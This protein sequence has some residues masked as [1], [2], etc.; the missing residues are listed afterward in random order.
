MP[1]RFLLVR[2]QPYQAN[3][4]R[5]RTALHKAVDGPGVEEIIETQDDKLQEIKQSVFSDVGGPVKLNA[6]PPVLVSSV[7]DIPAACHTIS[8]HYND[9]Q[10]SVIPGEKQDESNG[11]DI[12]F[13]KAEDFLQLETPIDARKDQSMLKIAYTIPKR[14]FMSRILRKYPLNKKRLAF[15][16]RRPL[17][18]K[19][20]DTGN[21]IVGEGKE[22]SITCQV[23]GQRFNR[24]HHFQRHILTHPDPDNKKFLCQVCGKRF[25]RPDHLNR[26]VMLHGDVKLQ[27]CVLC[28]EEFDRASHLDRHRRKHHPPAGQQPSQT[29]PLTPQLKSPPADIVMA[30][31]A[32]GFDGVGFVTNNVNSGSTG[33]GNNLHLLAAVA[34][35]DGSAGAQQ[36]VNPDT[37]V[38]NIFQPLSN[39]DFGPSVVEVEPERPFPCEVC[40][41]KFIRATHLRRHMR[42]HT[43]EKPFACHICG[44]RYAR[45]DY[46]R[47]HIHAHRRDKIHK[48]KHCG[49]VFQDLTRFADHCRLLH[50]DMD[51]EHGNP[52]PPP[53][54]SPPPVINTVFESTL[55]AES[56]ESITIVPSMPAWETRGD[57]PITL[58]NLA[59][60][61]DQQE[62][63]IGNYPG[64]PLPTPSHTPELHLAHL[65]HE[66][67][68]LMSNGQL[69]IPDTANEVTI[70]SQPPTLSVKPQGVEYMDPVAQYILNNSSIA[71]AGFPTPRQSPVIGQ[72]YP[73]QPAS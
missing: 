63:I 20:S 1:R 73:M 13:S 27:K 51:D 21:L 58:V 37:N 25:N 9:S 62:V 11:V 48:C 15:I 65:P 16:Q 32:I 24:Q 14:F 38:A 43:G 53:D 8:T 34:T 56:A 7:I 40:G 23:C 28:G 17:T 33:S 26:H 59:E 60:Q 41:R 31:T 69:G 42:I 2:D 68:S 64:H 35:P 66:T 72:G 50:K 54:T 39:I 36:P 18:T 57:I 5:L 30:P 29:P 55:A 52:R 4:D 46:L 45:G 67:H 3:S 6:T 61:E 70:L 47:A 44:R 19:S 12:D 49:E 10:E 22:V 71:S